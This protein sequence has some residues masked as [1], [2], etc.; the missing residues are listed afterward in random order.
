M[1]NE[2]VKRAFIDTEIPESNKKRVWGYFQRVARMENEYGKD[3]SNFT[4]TQILTTYKCILSTSIDYL[5]C[6]NCIFERYTRYCLARNLVRDGQNHFEELDQDLIQKRCVINTWAD[7]KLITREAL[8]NGIKDFFN[9]SDRLLVLGLF[10]G[11]GGNHMK[12]FTY[13]TMDNF[14]DGEVFLEDRH[15]TVSKELM[16]YAL[17]SAAET[18]YLI[19]NTGENLNDTRKL[20]PSSLLIKEKNGMIPDPS[21]ARQHIRLST[22]LKILQRYFSVPAYRQKSLRESGRIH[23]LRQKMEEEHTDLRETLHNHIDDADM[24]VRYGLITGRSVPL[25]MR[26]YERFFNSLG[27]R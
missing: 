1:Y 13:L 20:I 8:L 25:Y 22:R 3:L 18:E 10:E 2:E 7:R 24:I 12:D 27:L 9:A 16:D 14:K 15:F 23:W 26:K 4:V 21:L 6:I 17:E 19:Y 11:I 5:N